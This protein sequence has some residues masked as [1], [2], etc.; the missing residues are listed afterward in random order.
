MILTPAVL[1]VLWPTV[2]RKRKPERLKT[3]HK[4]NSVFPAVHAFQHLCTCY[5]NTIFTA[6]IYFVN[7]TEY[8]QLS[9]ARLCFVCKTWLGKVLISFFAH[10]TRSANQKPKRQ[11]SFLL[12]SDLMVRRSPT[13]WTALSPR[14]CTGC[15]N[16]ISLSIVEL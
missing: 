3:A 15:N 1:S 7:C 5:S 16:A 12:F 8:R 11:Q 2:L 9:R 6:I 4:P 14:H 13:R 10:N